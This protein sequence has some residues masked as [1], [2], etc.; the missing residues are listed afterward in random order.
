MVLSEIC[1]R[2]PVFASVLSLIIVL[3][4]LISYTRLGVREY[5]KIDEP[6]VSV[7]TTYK[8]ASPEVIESQVTKPLEDQLAGIEGVDVMTSRSRSERSLI[9]IKFSLSRDP[10]A[11]AAEVRDKVSRARRFLPDEI[12]E[13][14]IGKVEA[15][16]QPIIYIAVE[17][18]SYSAIQTSDYINRYIKTRLS[19][20]PGAAEVRVFGER[21]PSMRIYVDRDKLAAYGLTVQDVEAALRS[22][23]VEIPAGRI[24]S[25]AR[26][27]SVV[28]STDLQTPA[29][30][31]DVVVANVKGYPVRLRDVAKVEIGAANDRVLSRYNGRSA[32][33]IGLTRQSTANPLELSKAV[34][35]EIVQL[36]QSLPAGMKLNIAYD[37]SV[38]IERSID[39]VFKTIGEAIILV[40]LVIFFFLRNLRASIIP[41]VT[42][43]VSLV[44][45]CA[46]MYLFGFSI[47]TLTLLAMV[48]AIGLVVDDA[49]VVLENIFR[50][51]EEGMPRKQAAFQ[52]AREIG[53]AVVA[54][55]LTLV[56]VY[57]P[58]AFATGRTGRLF[59]EFALALAGAVLVS[60]FVAL[61]LTP[62]MCSVLLRHQHSHN[63]WYNL[64]EGW[65]EALGRGYRRALELALRHRWTVV[66]VGAVVAAASGVLFSV[67]K[68]ELAPI[69]DRGVVFGIVSAPEGAT[70]NYTL[71]SMLGIEQFY[72]AI[73]EAATAQVTVGF[74]TVTDGTAILRLTPWEERTRR[75]QQIAQELQPKF[76]SLPGVRAFP[77][78]PPSLGQSARSKPV[79]FIIMSQASYPE[80]A[81]L[82]GVFTNALRDYPGLQNIDTDLRLN[83]P[84][85]RVHVDRDKMADV[86][87][88]V[89]VVGRTLESMLGGRQVT[90]YKDQGEQYDVIVQVVQ[91]DRATPTDISGI[92]VRARDGS[93]VQLDNLLSVRESVSPQSLN[94]F[95]RLRAVKVDAAVA[96]GYAL[97]EVLD[98][99]HR[100]ARDVLPNT[101]ITDLDGQSREFRDSSGSIYLVFAMALAFIY[102]VLAAQFESWRNPFIIMLSVP[103]SMTGAL[104]ALWLTGGTLSIYSQIGLITLVGLITKHGI[105]IVEFANQL[106]DQGKAMHEAVVEASV[107]RLRPILMTTGAMVLGT[108]PLALA[109]GAGAESRQQIGWVL[110]G[111]LMLGTLLTL[112]VVPVAY[113]MI[114]AARPQGQRTGASHTGPAVVPPA[115]E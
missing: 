28:S 39:S 56:T 73:P 6:I 3:I 104:L 110:V 59:I 106:R 57:A 16:S 47:N 15:D 112:F 65:L 26:E 109:Q 115:L 1:I 8:G 90:R 69:E 46:L 17:S 22:Q 21:L 32:I 83:T 5:P 49:I 41:I 97:G 75:Q 79:E 45:A 18:G 12:D 9:N 40:V 37:S 100:V 2:R 7:D 29:Q 52:G 94:H 44:G 81:K 95:N 20:L 48:L 93:M 105:L 14:I 25:R 76:A 63:R 85:L 38:F 11:A 92:Y 87:A 62:M 4:G 51:I 82:V 43:P 98:H 33:N 68:S 96:P 102:L 35:A 54:M 88:S 36:N 89:E 101:V 108:V 99:M 71:D 70:L 42:I 78:N 58:L 113:S 64:I 27:F 34:R 107:L 13:P 61:T 84:E 77:T 60:G 10:D 72:A 103:L 74:P 23:N 66:G 91:G 24:E 53:F 67:V 114:A 19:V 31:E 50:H 55:T 86:G 80:L 111:G 30:F